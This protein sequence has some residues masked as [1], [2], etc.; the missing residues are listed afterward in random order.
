MINF[1]NKKIAVYSMQKKEI[2][3][4]KLSLD[5][6]SRIFEDIIIEGS[7]QDLLGSE[8]M[9]RIIDAA[10]VCI[11]MEGEAEIAVESK[12]YLIKKGDMCVVFPEDILHVRKKSKD[13]KGLIFVLTPNFLYSINIPA[14]TQIY[15]FMKEHRCISLSDKEREDLIKMYEDMKTYDARLDHPYRREISQHLV[16]AIVYEIISLYK[17]G[18]PFNQQSYSRKDQIYFDFME[19]VNTNF[20]KE[21]GIEFYA[22]KLCISSRHLTSICK[23]LGGQTAKKCIDEQIIIN[24]E[25]LLSTTTLTIA[26]ISDEFNF[27]NASFFTKYFKEHTGITPKEYRNGDKAKRNF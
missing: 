6:N 25:M 18:E 14:S 26:Q 22:D 27:P 1:G 19:L 9:P 15:L 17:K 24:I 8:R 16:T 12:K 13:F 5:D 3:L 7:E 4:E 2:Q 11:C 21:R 20:K 10:G 23:E